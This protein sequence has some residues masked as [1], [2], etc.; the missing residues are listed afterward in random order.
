MKNRRKLSCT[1]L[2]AFLQDCWTAFSYHEL[3]RQD[4]SLYVLLIFHNKDYFVHRYGRWGYM[5]DMSLFSG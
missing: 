2:T 3:I 1:V 5:Q 4:A